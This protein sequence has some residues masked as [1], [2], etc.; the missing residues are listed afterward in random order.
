M[1][2]QVIDAVLNAV[3]PEVR[4]VLGD[5]V[6]REIATAVDEGIR[7]AVKAADAARAPAIVAAVDALI[8]ATQAWNIYTVADNPDVIA[9]RRALL[10]TVGIEDD[11]A[12][13]DGESVTGGDAG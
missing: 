10:R 12:L 13:G 9:A 8:A 11:A 6:L 2:E 3:D 1:D 4:Y 5:D 7:A